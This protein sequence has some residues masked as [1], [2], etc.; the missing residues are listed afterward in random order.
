RLLKELRLQLP[1]CLLA[2]LVPGVLALGADRNVVGL[3]AVSFGLGCLLMGATAFGS[4]FEQRTLAGLVAQPLPRAMIYWEKIGVLVVLLGF[5]TFNLWLTVAIPDRF[6]LSV[7]DFLEIIPIALFA[8]CG[9]PL[10]SLLTRSTLAGLIFCIAIPVI[11]WLI[12]MLGLQWVYHW[13]YPAETLSDSWV[14]GLLRIGAP[15]YLLVAFALSWRVF[16]RLELRDAGAGGA[17]DSSLHPL[18]RPVDQVLARIFLAGSAIGQLIRKELRLQVVPWLVALLMIGLW[19]LWLALRSFTTND[20]LRDALN[21][22]SG[23]AVFTALLGTLTLLGTGATSV[24]EERELGTL[25]WQLTQPPSVRRQWW[26]KLSVTWVLGLLLGVVLP[27][28]LLW[29]GFRDYPGL[30]TWSYEHTLATVASVGA[31]FSVL[32]ISI[33]ASTISRNTMKAAATASG[34]AVGLVGLVSLA[35]TAM[36]PVFRAW[37][38]KVQAD[39]ESNQISPPPWAPSPDFIQNLALSAAAGAGILVVAALL[40]MARRNFPCQRVSNRTIFRQL[41]GLS[42]GT[43][44]LTITTGAIFAQLVELQVRASWVNNQDM[45]REQLIQ[46]ISGEARLGRLWPDLYSKFGLTTNASPE[47]LAEAIIA[48]YGVRRAFEELNFVLSRAI[49]R[50]GG[51]R[52]D[53]QLAAR[54]GLMPTTNRPSGFPELKFSTSDDKAKPPR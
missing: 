53:P 14:E 13:Q 5:A 22:F 12:A 44:L 49:Q 24:A 35:V 39:W 25:E 8:F 16:L 19:V 38:E 1:G 29:I 4:E 40:W 54:Y 32:A 48:A 52:L 7:N 15:A 33:Y 42:L 41:A 3:V 23:I 51:V 27:A 6:A 45:L 46:R 17:K 10:F 30:D 28:S 43:L 26:I 47:S 11:L 9:G 31:I 2:V 50:E 21:Y 34:I 37:E 36:A 20:E 18:S